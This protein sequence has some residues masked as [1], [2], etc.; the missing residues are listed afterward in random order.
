MN[1]SIDVIIIVVIFIYTDTGMH[2]HSMYTMCNISEQKC[3][4]V[5]SPASLVNS[6]KVVGSMS[7]HNSTVIWT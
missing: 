3:L 4:S 1:V 7:V 5:S 2:V 6:T